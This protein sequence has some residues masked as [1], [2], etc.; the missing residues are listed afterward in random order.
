MTRSKIISKF[1]ACTF[2]LSTDGS[3]LQSIDLGAWTQN[4]RASRT[5]FASVE[6]VARPSLRFGFLLLLCFAP[7]QICTISAVAET[8]DFD[9][10][11]GLLLVSGVE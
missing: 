10:D 9:G 8:S 11:I 1:L 6:I 3:V 7:F 2:Q 5:S 4:S